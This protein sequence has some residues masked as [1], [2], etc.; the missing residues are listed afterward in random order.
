MIKKQIIQYLKKHSLIIPTLEKINLIFKKKILKN[1]ITILQK[2]NI[3]FF[4]VGT[5]TVAMQKIAIYLKRNIRRSNR[6]EDDGSFAKHE[7]KTIGKSELRLVGLFLQQ[8][9]GC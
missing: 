2:K 6:K 8:S 9:C 1:L 5:L 7:Q 4:S 3:I